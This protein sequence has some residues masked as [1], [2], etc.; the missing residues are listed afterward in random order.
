M[1]RYY[2]RKDINTYKSRKYD[3][4]KIEQNI[5]NIINGDIFSL[6]FSPLKRAFITFKETKQNKR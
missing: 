5:E 1:A 4:E 2:K 6:L 3:W